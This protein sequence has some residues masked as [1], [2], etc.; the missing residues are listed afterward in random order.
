MLFCNVRNDLL[1]G[2]M[3]KQSWEEDLSGEAAQ[4]VRKQVAACPQNC[5]MVSSAKTAIRNKHFRD[6]Q[7]L[8]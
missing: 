5:W 2:N 4:A 6:C 7:S 3:H 8:L 1:M